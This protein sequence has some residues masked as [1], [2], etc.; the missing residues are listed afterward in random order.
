M[1][2]T[3][4]LMI[5]S[6]TLAGLACGC[7]ESSKNES[8]CS[9]GAVECV[10]ADKSRRCEGGKWVEIPCNAPDTCQKGICGPAGNTCTEEGK[11]ECLGSDKYKKCE[12]GEWK[13]NACEAP[14]TCSNNVCGPASNSCSEEGKVECLSSD[15]Y[16]KC[17]GGEWK[18][19]A[20]EAPNT[21]SNNVCGPVDNSCSEEGKVECLSS[22]KYKKCEGGEWKEN[23]CEAPN[24][25]SN[26]VCGPVAETCTEEGKIECL[27]TDRY[28]KCEGGVWKENAC[29]AN[30][31]CGAQGCAAS[32]IVD[33]LNSGTLADVGKLCDLN[34]FADSC[35]DN[36]MIF[37]DA[38]GHID[39][40]DTCKLWQEASG[41][42]MR[43]TVVNGIAGCI[44]YEDDA[45]EDCDP[46]TKPVTITCSND[47]TKA[48]HKGCG[49]GADGNHYLM[50]EYDFAEICAME[51]RAGDGCIEIPADERCDVATFKQSCDS[52]N[53]VVSCVNGHLVTTPCGSQTCRQ[54]ADT[55]IAT[56][57][58][59][60]CDAAGEIISC[61]YKPVS[62]GMDY[63]IFADISMCARADDGNLYMYQTKSE[64]CE[65]DCQ[66]NIGCVP[67]IK[68]V[69]DDCNEDV[70][71][72]KC[73]DAENYSVSLSCI[74]STVE[75]VYCGKGL[76]CLNEMDSPT[77]ASG[78]YDDS[79][80][81][82]QGSASYTKCSG[83][84]Y[85]TTSTYE[86]KRMSDNKYHYTPNPE[87]NVTCTNGCNEDASGC[88]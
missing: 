85:V 5:L 72:E 58:D 71:E 41:V 32:S 88:K 4:F 73:I 82:A 34:D 47:G 3:V 37:C 56:C 6:G 81:C 63:H 61:N 12:G 67:Y 1:K 75:A 59:N 7:S 78:C 22:D 8:E 35:E 16:K 19:N 40:S 80:I 70:Y 26:N 18:E 76:V 83:T 53:N 65:N 20:C 30:Q 9:D 23:A 15:K 86:C 14:N 52:S 74:N 46:E 33:V 29:E 69:G 2:K 28:K 42:D 31:T 36:L 43:C 27:S 50:G 77:L 62:G 24:A 39:S 25:C 64:Y 49:L 45:P 68:G 84:S 44:Y 55:G 60:T 79:S 57:T 54:F 38:G 10:D 13:E 11:V 48:Y 17:E 66:N 87:L 21:C 51:C